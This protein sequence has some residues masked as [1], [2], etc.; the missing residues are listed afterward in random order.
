MGGPLQHGANR[1][2]MLVLG[3]LGSWVFF[4]LVIWQ[5]RTARQ[6][7]ERARRLDQLA[8]EARLSALRYQINPHFL[9]N[10]LASIGA[11]S[12]EAP[13]RIPLLVRNLA[14]YLRV[15][16]RPDAGET[17]AFA[18]EWESIRAYLEI[19]QI[20]FSDSLLIRHDV[21][22]EALKARV[23][24]MLV[25]PLVENAVTHGFREDGVADVCFSARRVGKGQT[26]RRKPLIYKDWNV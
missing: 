18:E 17:H 23:P 25:Q 4:A 10:T 24:E 7:A 15:R 9:F 5:Q 1:N 19:E 16:L 12:T 3:I 22:G 14:A 11:L 8:T 20:R 13:E 26:L 21:R 2:L 6:K